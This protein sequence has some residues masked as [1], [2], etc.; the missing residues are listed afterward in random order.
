MTAVN[1][2]TPNMP[3]FETVNVEA[4]SSSGESRRRCARAARSR[5][6]AAI[7]GERLAVGVDDRGH[8]QRILR[9]HGDADVHP[10]VA[11]APPVDERAVERG[12]LAQRQRRRP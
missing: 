8:E 6:S 7:D 10:A 5:V 3:R 11:L 2:R 1:E 4:V 12:V 9:G